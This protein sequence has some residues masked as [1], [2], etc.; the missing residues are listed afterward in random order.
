MATMGARD[1]HLHSYAVAGDLN[2]SPAPPPPSPARTPPP[3]FPTHTP[4]IASPPG[5]TGCQGSTKDVTGRDSKFAV[6]LGAQWGDEGKGKLVDILA[7]VR[8][9][10]GRTPC[11]FHRGFCS[12]NRGPTPSPR[13]ECNISKSC[14]IK[15]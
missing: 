10:V 1:S 5:A 6:V 9:R 15:M 13:A 8:A 14:R 12:L 11:L 7:Q 2:S 3:P 4:P